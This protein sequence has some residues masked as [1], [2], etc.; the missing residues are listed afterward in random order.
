VVTKKTR[1]ENLRSQTDP[2]Q[3]AS[4]KFAQEFVIRSVKK[5]DW[6]VLVTVLKTPQKTNLINFANG[7]GNPKR[8]AEY[9]RVWNY[10]EIL[11]GTVSPLPL[12]LT[13]DTENSFEEPTNIKHSES[14]DKQQEVSEVVV[15]PKEA[16]NLLKI[17]K[18]KEVANLLKIEKPKEADNLL[19]IEKPEEE[20]NLLKIEKPKEAANLLKIEKPKE[21]P[22]GKQSLEDLTQQFGA[23]KLCFP[24]RMVPWPGK[25]ILY[26]EY[27]CGHLIKLNNQ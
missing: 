9:N 16:D 7:S 20:A 23:L 21:E 13:D 22:D 14:L 5:T 27:G 17:E 24:H 26:C 19:K 11:E 18:P 4:W 2:L 3:H 6:D 15:E 1:F 25:D 8:F 12:D 10:I